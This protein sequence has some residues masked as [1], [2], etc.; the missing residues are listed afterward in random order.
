M[1]NILK[2][3]F[4]EKEDTTSAGTN[5]MESHGIFVEDC[6][7]AAEKPKGEVKY[8]DDSKSY[9]AIR[10]ELLFTTLKK[11]FRLSRKRFLKNYAL[12]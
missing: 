10:V 8:L 2:T 5:R 3:R 1:Q 7:L 11:P 12:V 9:E 4:S 6:W